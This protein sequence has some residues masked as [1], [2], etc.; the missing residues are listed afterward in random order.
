MLNFFRRGKRVQQ[1]S[2]SVEDRNIVNH[3]DITDELKDQEILDFYPY[4]IIKN[5]VTNKRNQHL[6]VVF[7]QDGESSTK[8]SWAIRLYNKR[9]FPLGI[10]PQLFFDVFKQKDKVYIEIVDVVMYG[11][12]NRGNGTLVLKELIKYAVEIGA[13]HIEG[14]LIPESE[15][16]T[17]LRNHFYEKQGFKIIKNSQGE[18]NWCRL[19]L[20]SPAK[21]TID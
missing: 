17:S 12:L 19:D 11:S 9:N 8:E 3:K 20:N 16:M 5:H 14:V 1:E 4:M 18:D 13:T 21:L 10:V 15:E 7:E 2:I 6:T